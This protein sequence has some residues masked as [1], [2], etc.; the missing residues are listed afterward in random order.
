MISVLTL[1]YQRYSILE[2]AI[3]SYLSQ[4]Y[5]GESE[6]III[7]D[8]PNVEYV[9][10][11]PN[12]K[13]FNCKE[14]FKSISA[15]LEFGYKQC[16]YD[17]IY[18]LDDD[19]LLTPWALTLIDQYIKENTDYEVYRSTHSYLFTDNKFTSKFESINT[20]NVYT[21]EYLN[22]IIFPNKSGDED[23]EI[24][25][26]NNSK[27]ITVDKGKYTMIYRWGGDTYH[28]SN[29]DLGFYLPLNNEEVLSL[30][31]KNIKNIETGII[32]LSPSFKNDYYSQ[33]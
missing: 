27:V 15:K 14:R 6:M 32:K 31:D 9:Y 17:Y 25:F 1:T 24:T 8:S 11:H 28:I 16:R 13:I 30:T 22:R 20:G 33:L 4:D 19:D 5:I 29:T 7:N 10:E 26:G 3:Q 21:K 18:R 12:I 23:V 2:E